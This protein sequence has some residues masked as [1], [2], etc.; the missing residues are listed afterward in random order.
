VDPRSKDELLRENNEL[1]Q[2]LQA[3]VMLASAVLAG[4]DVADD[5]QTWIDAVNAFVASRR[6]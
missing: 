4:D 2:L 6:P 5:L 3:G 1:R